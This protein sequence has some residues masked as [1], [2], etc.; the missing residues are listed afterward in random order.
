[1]DSLWLRTCLMMLKHDGDRMTCPR[2]LKNRMRSL[3][4]ALH[5]VKVTLIM[6]CRH[7]FYFP[8]LYFAGCWRRFFW[9]VVRSNQI[10]WIFLKRCYYKIQILY[11][12][13]GLML[14]PTLEQCSALS[15][16]SKALEFSAKFSLF[17]QFYVIWIPVLIVLLFL[18]CLET[19]H[20]NL[21]VGS[22][23]PVTLEVRTRS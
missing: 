9:I 8:C 6:Q 12:I 22:S 2:G 17:C 15:G 20:M 13:S 1:M 7:S 3:S 18:Q 14:W 11:L 16:W 10:W 5:V 21:G 19:D 23:F 4:L